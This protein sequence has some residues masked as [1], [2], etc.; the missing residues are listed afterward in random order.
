MVSTSVAGEFVRR[1][2]YP[3]RDVVVAQFRVFGVDGRGVKS[4][5]ATVGIEGKF[6]TLFIVFIAVV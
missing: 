4:E 2:L 3:D 5:P 1:D 6:L